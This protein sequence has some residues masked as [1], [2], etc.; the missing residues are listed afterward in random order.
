ME[1]RVEGGRLDPGSSSLDVGYVRVHY[2]F[3]HFYN[4][5]E[6]FHMRMFKELGRPN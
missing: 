5:L 3:P 1:R 6:M 4:L 2:P